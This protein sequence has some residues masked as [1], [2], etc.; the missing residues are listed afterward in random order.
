[1]RVALIQLA[2]GTD[3]EH[4][5]AGVRQRLDRLDPRVELVVLPEGAMHDFGPPDHDLAAAAESLDGPFVGMLVEQA[6]RLDATV[7]GHI[8]ERHERHE[9]GGLPYNTTVAIGPDGSMLGAYR[10]I[11]LYDSFGDVESE[12]LSPGPLTPVVV[13][14]GE[15]RIG[16]L[17]CYDLRFP[18][19]VRL[20][21]DAGADV[22]AV[23]TAW[24]RGPLKEDHWETLLRARAIENTVYALGVAQCGANY[25][26]RSLVVDP[27]GVVIAGAG[28]DEADVV[29]DI[30]PERI[31]VARR[32]NPSLANR[33]IPIVPPAEPP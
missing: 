13:G 30:T 9:S 33:R 31:A 29:A 1:M 5:R 23:P 22:L 19:F 18:E 27:M 4:N 10:K 7:I 2:A 25:T 15:L 6:R 21:V 24:V 8:F 32:R 3:S 14:V 28:A 11:H 20:L 16:L 17:T 12:R 26:G